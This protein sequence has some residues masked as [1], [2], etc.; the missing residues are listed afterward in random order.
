[1]ATLTVLGAPPA[2]AAGE[3]HALIVTGAPGGSQ[4]AEKYRAWRT[5]LTA[6]LRETFG[7]PADHVIELA[8][9]GE[10]GV[11]AA[12]RENVR[13]AVATLR[14]RVAAEDVVLVLLIGHGTAGSAGGLEGL[15]SLEGSDAKFNLV[16]P[17]LTAAE[18]A[19]L[20]DPIAGQLVF[21]NA[22][23][24]SFPFLRPL[25]RRG[26]VVITATDIAAQQ[27]ETVFPEYFVKAFDEPGADL[28]KND[29]V[30]IW[31]AFSYAADGV[32]TWF[33]AHGQLATERPLLDDSGDGVGSEAG[34]GAVD[35]GLARLLHLQPDAP[36]AA[37]PALTELLRRRAELESQIEGLKANKP[38]LPAGEYEARLEELLLELARVEQR[39][40]EKR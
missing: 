5:T 10:A 3:G 11:R 35:G 31:E 33:E 8:G 17:D 18:W 34:A 32:R 27:F 29:R 22:A 9:D 6:A 2:L 37:D 1:V 39:V 30:S 38:A 16:G 25:S 28:D 20:L 4:Y 36:I 14:E 7:Y 21:V 12:T 19:E 26:R 23:S 40:R 15:D 13:A 24:A